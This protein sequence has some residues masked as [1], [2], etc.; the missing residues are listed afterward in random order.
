[1]CAAAVSTMARLIAATMNR[2]AI[3]SLVAPMSRQSLKI[4]RKWHN[5]QIPSHSHKDKSYKNDILLSLLAG[6]F[7]G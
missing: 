7:Q 2:A 4:D 6:S 3:E 5:R 1:M